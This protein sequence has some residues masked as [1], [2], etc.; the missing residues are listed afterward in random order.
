MT[1]LQSKP[2]PSLAVT[3]SWVSLVSALGSTLWFG[4]LIVLQNTFD[5]KFSSPDPVA[6]IAILIPLMGA[7]I[8]ISSGILGFLLMGKGNAQ[9]RIF[10]II[11]RNTMGILWGSILGV[12]L[13]FTWGMIT[14]GL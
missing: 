9:G 3:A 2:K 1:E 13:Y 11:G 6:G 14:Y 5:W 7:G 4:I 8:A 10:G 12:P